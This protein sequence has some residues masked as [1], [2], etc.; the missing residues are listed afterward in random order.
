MKTYSFEFII[1]LIVIFIAGW[2]LIGVL[3]KSEEISNLGEVT[4]Y[5]ASFDDIS[6]I[7]VGSEIKLAGVTIGRVKKLS[8]DSFSYTAEVVLE[9]SSKIKLPS[10]HVS[11]IL[12]IIAGTLWALTVVQILVPFPSLTLVMVGLLICYVLG[13]IPRLSWYAQ[14]VCGVLVVGAVTLAWS[15]SE[16]PA[17][18]TGI[19]K[20]SIFP[21]FLSTIV[22]LTL[23]FVIQSY[24]AF[25]L[26]APSFQS[27]SS[28]VCRALGT[29]SELYVS[30][31]CPNQ[32]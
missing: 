31:L 14:V 15:F 6:G 11:R 24:V 25:L 26:Q 9:I 3:L 4:E 23:T 12:S 10:D 28:L 22:L 27:R 29:F 20:A 18:L 32:K 1:G 2:F 17:L 8:L 21:A 30:V 5:S 19:A 16:W 7:S 13:A